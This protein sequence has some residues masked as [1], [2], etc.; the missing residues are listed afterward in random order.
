MDSLQA[1]LKIASS[2]LDA[3]SRRVRVASENLANASS[4]GRAPG[5]DP[6][7]RKTISFETEFNDALGASLVKVSAVGE[8]RSSF[9]L[10]HDP[11]HP[12]ADANGMV[13][14]PNVNILVEMADIREATR[15]YEANLQV[16][17]RARE[18]LS[19]TIDMLRSVG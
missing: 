3:Q 2:G 4:T 15:T 17:K 14:T 9:K 7:A 1:A 5:A 11:Q 13:K 6:Y 12:A 10:E 8:D 19:Q 18:M 16:V